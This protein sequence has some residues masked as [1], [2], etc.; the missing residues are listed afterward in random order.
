MGLAPAEL[1]RAPGAARVA[2][3][4]LLSL[5]P[6]AIA[7]A[8][9]WRPL[10]DATYHELILPA[11]LS[12]PLPLRV[13][14][15][16]TLPVIAIVVA[17]LL[18]DAAAAVGV[19]RLVLERRRVFEAWL[20]G[21]ADLVRR[22]H[23]IVPTALAGLLA[24]VLLTGPALAAAAIGWGR[25][26]DILVAGQDPVIMIVAVMVWVAIWL[27]CLVLA[28]VGS[29]VRAAMWTIEVPTR[30]A[31]HPAIAGEP[32]PGHPPEAPASPG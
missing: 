5:A 24:L 9:A 4:R 11:D 1:E 10:Y 13:I 6:V 12:T 26:R 19:R 32:G 3:V 22:P 2:A 23:R 18:A 15:E 28:G 27:G 20:L 21:W 17:W 16:A 31:G 7:V 30:P 14:R 25:V 8:L 29:A